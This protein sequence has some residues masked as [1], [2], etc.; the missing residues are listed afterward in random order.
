[1]PGD[2]V[3]IG[4]AEEL[5]RL[6]PF[7]QGNAK[8]TLLVPAARVADVR[9]MGQEG[10]HASFTLVGGGARARVVALR[11]EAR[12]LPASAD[13]RVDAAV[14]LELNEWNGAVE[15]RLVLRALC[16][17]EP[18]SV[19]LVGPRAAAAAGTR[20]I[21]DRRQSG[22]AGVLGDLLSSGE[23][24][25]LV[26]A[27]ALR[28]RPALELL[29]DGRGVAATSW[30]ELLAGPGLAEPYAHVVAL[31]PPVAPEEVDALVT[32]PGSGFAYKAWGPAE[33]E[34]ALAVARR[35]LDPRDE[36]VVL[37][38]ALRD[39]SP[40]T[41]VS[42]AALEAILLDGRSE[43]QAARLLAILEEIGVVELGPEP[44]CRVIEARRADLDS[45]AAYRQGRE[46]L[47]RAEAWL[48]GTAALAA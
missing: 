3:G 23:P 30:D 18:G 32:L 44:S 17:T 31:D 11:R 28:R 26:C 35:T 16:P 20:A 12:S 19:Q 4:L 27:D 34:F 39:A 13:E 10:Q 21:V 48:G 43:F 36:L 46:R 9:P 6:R 40:P 24:V 15:P 45:S 41:P 33:V 25:L 5:E 29:S 8:P 22:F 2:A 42:G 7:G 38:R 14:R 37:Y 47:E 1:V